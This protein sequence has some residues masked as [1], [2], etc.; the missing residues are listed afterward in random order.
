MFPQLL[1]VVGVEL[2]VFGSTRDSDISH[3]AVEQVFC[4]QGGIDVNQ[5]PFGSL[6][7]A[8]MARHPITVIEMGCSRGSGRRGSR[9]E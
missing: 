9:L 2:R 6:S 8:R 3:A 5:Y 7:L 1:A 4:G